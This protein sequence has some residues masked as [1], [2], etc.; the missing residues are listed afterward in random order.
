MLERL[1]TYMDM[2][3][4]PGYPW[5]PDEHARSPGTEVII[6]GEPPRGFWDLNYSLQEQH[7]PSTT[8]LPLQTVK[9][10]KNHGYLNSQA[11]KCI[12]FITKKACK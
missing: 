12:N 4:C 1:L 8:E 2:H 3:M 11:L 9:V 7:V 10:F 6:G 5:R